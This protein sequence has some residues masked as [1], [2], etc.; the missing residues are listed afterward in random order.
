MKKADKLKKDVEEWMEEGK[1]KGSYSY[2]AT[3]KDCLKKAKADKNGVET[4]MEDKDFL[5][6]L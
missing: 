3:V 6:H 1:M 5:F 2:V 4:I